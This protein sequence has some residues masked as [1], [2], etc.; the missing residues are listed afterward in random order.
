M[1]Y[2]KRIL[3]VPFVFG[4]L[5][6]THLFFVC[7]RTFKFIRGGGELMLKEEKDHELIKP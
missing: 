4:I 6:V 2:I 3:V 7:K 1:K 5:L